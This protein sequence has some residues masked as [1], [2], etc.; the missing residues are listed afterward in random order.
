M[1]MVSAYFR[2]QGAVVAWQLPGT[3]WLFVTLGIGATMG[4]VIYATLTRINKGPQFTAVLL[5]AIAFTAGMASFLRLSTISVSFIAGAIVANLGGEWREPLRDLLVRLERPV[6][7]V[8]LVIAGAL[9]RP[10]EWQGWIL[11][12]VFVAS[13]F[14]SKWL[15]AALLEKFW[16][17]DLTLAERRTLIGAPVGALSVAIVVSAQDLFSGPTVAWIVTAVIGGAI[18][19]EI[20]LQLAARRAARQLPASHD[21]ASSA[22]EVS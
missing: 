4:I 7:F 21:A 11:M 22:Y 18:I 3:A 1:M 19:M 13:R 12:L 16:I 14:S 17:R 20:A 15:A 10:W 2:P 6:Y 5:G 9:W 8:F